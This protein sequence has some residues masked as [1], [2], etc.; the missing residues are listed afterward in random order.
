MSVTPMGELMSHQRT[1]DIGTAHSSYFGDQSRAVR[2]MYLGSCTSR[3]TCVPLY[4]MI[5]LMYKLRE[6]E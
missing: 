2:D 4:L 6:N 3:A 5:R 1:T